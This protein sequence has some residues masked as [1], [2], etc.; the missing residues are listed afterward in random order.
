MTLRNLTRDANAF[1]G[2]FSLLP[3][4]CVQSPIC[5]Q[6]SNQLHQL[7]RLSASR[8]VQSSFYSTASNCSLWA[9]CCFPNYGRTSS[10][11]MT[12][13]LNLARVFTI[14][15]KTGLP[16]HLKSS[17]DIRTNISTACGAARRLKCRAGF[18]NATTAQ[19]SSPSWFF[20][21]VPTT[22]CHLP[23]FAWNISASLPSIRTSPVVIKH[24]KMSGLDTVLP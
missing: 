1:S 23:H 16:T 19:L 3:K 20:G 9:D 7:N 8:T 13:Y 17:L 2:S 24:M 12:R 11:P 5:N 18:P 22:E 15:V 4:S 14:R 21:A 10:S 6:K